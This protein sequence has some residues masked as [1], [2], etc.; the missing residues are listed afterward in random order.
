MD[1]REKFLYA[2]LIRILILLL[3]LTALPLLLGAQDIAPDWV[4]SLQLSSPV[5]IG[6]L[7]LPPG[8]FT[9]RHT[10]EGDRHMLIFQQ[11]NKGAQQ[12]RVFCT[13][14]QLPGKAA[15]NEQLYRHGPAGEWILVGLIFKGDKVEHRF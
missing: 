15:N 14:V 10:M 12:F 2:V 5:Q 7:R 13:L 4:R 8:E 3:I 6:E 1:T 11:K 9:V